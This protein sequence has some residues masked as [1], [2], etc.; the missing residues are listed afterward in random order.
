M[1]R[2][3]YISEQVNCSNS[4]S[5]NTGN[6]GRKQKYV[7]RKMLY[8]VQLKLDFSKKTYIRTGNYTG[9]QE[10]KTTGRDESLQKRVC[11]AVLYPNEYVD[12]SAPVS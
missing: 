5:Q 1:L 7:N 4:S 3:E 12:Q 10:K 6:L 9:R 11:S 8:K 2:S